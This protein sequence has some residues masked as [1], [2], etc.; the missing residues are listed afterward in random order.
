[1]LE[2]AATHII[3]PPLLTVAAEVLLNRYGLLAAGVPEPVKVVV[4]PTSTVC[5][6]VIV[7]KAL[8]V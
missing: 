6:P 7:S 4:L 3:T 2:P 1:V 8:T 5:V